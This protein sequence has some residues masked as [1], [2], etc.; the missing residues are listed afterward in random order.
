MKYSEMEMVDFVQ[1]GNYYRGKIVHSLNLN[2]TTYY[3]VAV[4]KSL[5]LTLNFEVIEENIVQVVDKRKTGL[6]EEWCAEF[7]Y[8]GSPHEKHMIEVF[9]NGLCFVFA[10]WLQKH[11]YNSRI[12]YLIEEHHYVVE[13]AGYLYDITGNVT[14]KYKDCTSRGAVFYGDWVKFR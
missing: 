8:S 14:E 5:D 11:L 4:L 3:S 6:P 1:D 2:N 13:F 10:E 12:V 7:R 9:T